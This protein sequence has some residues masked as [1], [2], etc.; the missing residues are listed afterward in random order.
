MRRPARAASALALLVAGVTVAAFLPTLDNGFVD[1][2][3][4]T[5]FLQNPHYRG[6]GP[7]QLRWMLTESHRGHYVPVTWLT[8]GLDYVVWGLDPRGYHLGSLAWH[9]VA[10]VLCFWTTRRLLSHAGAFSEAAR[11]LGAAATALLFAIHPLRVESVAWATERRD[12][13]SGALFLLMVGLH[14]RAVETDG[15]RRVGFRVA[16]VAAFA[17]AIGAKSIVMS[18]P[19]ILLLL[20]LYPLRRLPPD[21]RAWR[22]ASARRVLAEKLPY[23]LLSLGA[24]LV[25]YRAQVAD[26]AFDRVATWPE[27]LANVAFSLAFYLRQTLVPV[28]LSPLYEAPARIDP[29]APVFV[30]S[31]A[32][33]AALTAACLALRRRAP[34]GLAALAAYGL[35]LAPVSGVLPL[36]FQLAAD[37][38]TY[39][40]CVGWAMVAG[41]VVAGVVDATR[42]RRIRRSLAGL[43]AGV[44][45]LGLLGLGGLTWRQVRVWHDPGSL[46]SHAVAVTPECSICHAQLGTWLLGRGDATGA[47]RHYEV[48]VALRP[49]RVRMLEP[50]GHA[51]LRLG[52]P[53]EA[54]PP[55]TRFLARYPDVLPAR[56]ALATALVDLGRAG[57]AAAELRHGVRQ[58]SMDDALAY[59]RWAVEREP[60]RPILRAALGEAYRAG[61]RAD[62]AREQDDALRRL[63]PALAAALAAGPAAAP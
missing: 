4:V 21:P 2:D 27:R 22:G 24:A 48:T 60:A 49:D 46:W 43:L 23:V 20:D 54:I 13:V 62:L 15:R 18:G 26:V 53:A 47:L 14:V 30:W 59:L 56:L 38:Y 63:A 19:L 58:G 33:V 3:D 8:L 52:R 6:L 17:L 39:L 34:A 40:A 45:V 10:A 36:G 5:N 28:A 31:A 12:V 50:M 29:L 11:T 51:Y 25:A 61:G 42:A 44:A 1:F 37:R 57:D 35:I 55:L 41:G 16:S 32:A 9:V 7:A